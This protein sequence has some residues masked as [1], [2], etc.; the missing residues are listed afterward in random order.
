MLY[1]RSLIYNIACLINLISSFLFLIPV[2][3]L[4]MQQLKKYISVVAKRGADT[5]KL[6]KKENSNDD[7]SYKSL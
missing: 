3:Y 1:V 6:I 7:E 2:S 4:L 5:Y